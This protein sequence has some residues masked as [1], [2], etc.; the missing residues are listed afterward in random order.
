MGNTVAMVCVRDGGR[1]KW[2][3]HKFVEQRQPRDARRTH[4]L[5]GVERDAERQRV[6][7]AIEAPRRLQRHLEAVHLDAVGVG[8]ADPLP[9]AINIIRVVID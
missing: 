5:P 2:R 8:G 4:L 9:N 6:L 7:L 3:R 1:G